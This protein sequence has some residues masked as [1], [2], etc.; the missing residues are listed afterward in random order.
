MYHDYIKRKDIL[1]SLF[2]AGTENL[3]YT[4]SAREVYD[5]VLTAY[6]PDREHMTQTEWEIYVERVK[7]RVLEQAAWKPIECL[8]LSARSNKIFIKNYGLKTIGDL[9]FLPP[10]KLI[11]M[12]GVSGRALAELRDRLDTLLETMEG[13]ANE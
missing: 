8:R 9:L 1:L 5:A 6:T 10:K 3:D 13:D 12:R 7:P 11:D 4:M 2:P